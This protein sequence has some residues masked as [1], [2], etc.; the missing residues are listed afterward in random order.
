MRHLLQ[1]SVPANWVCLWSIHSL[2]ERRA[3]SPPR[4]SFPKSQ[5]WARRAHTCTESTP[6]N[7]AP[8]GLGHPADSILFPLNGSCVTKDNLASPWRSYLRG[9]WVALRLTSNLR[10]LY[11]AL[12]T[13]HPSFLT[14]LLFLR[15]C[16]SL[17][18]KW[19]AEGCPG[20]LAGC[21]VDSPTNPDTLP[22]RM[23][24]W[25]NLR[26]ATAWRADSYMP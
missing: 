19:S 13:S 18:L 5:H 10:F 15:F 26:K 24:G 16:F 9:I 6:Y 7:A 21:P 22:M 14:G 12:R 1:T 2:S 23:D 8:R 20:N 3:K 17:H 25:I 11:F 4:Q